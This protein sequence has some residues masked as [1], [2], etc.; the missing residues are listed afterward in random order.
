MNKFKNKYPIVWLA[1]S[2]E[3]NKQ[4]EIKKRTLKKNR[5]GQFQEKPKIR[6]RPLRRNIKEKKG[7]RNYYYYLI[8]VDE[9]DV[10]NS[11]KVHTSEN[12][13]LTERV[14]YHTRKE[15]A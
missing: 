10:R 8:R 5:L 14:R 7:E 6:I 2:K 3:I 1:S 9:V 13:F 15:N 11:Q 12:L 4:Q